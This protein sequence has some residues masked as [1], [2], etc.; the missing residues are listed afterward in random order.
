MEVVLLKAIP[1][2]F[3]TVVNFGTIFAY[4]KTNRIF[5]MKKF[6]IAIVFALMSITA[7]GQLTKVRNHYELKLGDYVFEQDVP[8]LIEN[9]DEIF[10]TNLL[11]K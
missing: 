6:I 1:K 10:T 7:F 9:V 11:R 3:I 8:F 5:I 2:F 4:S